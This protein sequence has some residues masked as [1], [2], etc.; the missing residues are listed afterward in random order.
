MLKLDK[1]KVP[2]SIHK[3]GNT[4]GASLP[5]TIISELRDEIRN[6]K[7][8]ILLAAFGIGLSWGT[9][10]VETNNIVCPEIIELEQ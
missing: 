7:L 4:S 6:K 5:L 2:Y 9:A 1:E 10:F 3:Y 8:K